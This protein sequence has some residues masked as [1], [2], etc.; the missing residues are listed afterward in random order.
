MK[1]RSKRSRPDSSQDWLVHAK[2]DLNLAHLAR[3][4]KAILAEQVC[5][6][7]QQACEKALKAVL[8]F[9][10]LKFP[11]VHD[12]EVL[13]EIAKDGGLRLPR[14]VGEAGALSPYAV[15]ARYP[16][17]EEEITPAD[18]DE[19]I[20]LAERVVAWASSMLSTRSKMQ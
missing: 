12:I 20:R 10:G 7:A 11:L 16:G 19:A 14:K 15:E 3:S 4:H 2:S 1:P 9:K 13:L 5:F 17:Y 8:L 6:H 18:V